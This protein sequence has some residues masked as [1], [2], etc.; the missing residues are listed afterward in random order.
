MSRDGFGESGSCKFGMG[1]T[2]S[3][4]AQCQAANFFQ[5]IL[6]LSDN[7]FSPVLSLVLVVDRITAPLCL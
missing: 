4:H 7:G 5:Q 6:V 2:V 1:P 3:W